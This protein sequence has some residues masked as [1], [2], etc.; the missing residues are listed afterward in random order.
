MS[1]A[2]GA[3]VRDVA[4]LGMLA[5]RARVYGWRGSPN[6]VSVEADSTNLPMYMMATASLMNLT[7]ERSCE[8]NR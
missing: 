1:P 3:F 4:R 7:T 2:R 8:I 6:S 5:I